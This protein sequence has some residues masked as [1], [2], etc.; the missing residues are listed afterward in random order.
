VLGIV[1]GHGGFV[2]VASKVGQ[3]TTFELY[4]PATKAEQVALKKESAT[5]WPRAHSEGIL[6]VD[7]EAAV[8]E[9]T[10]QALVEFGYRVITAGR[11][12]EAI[13]IFQERR[14]EI[15]LVLTD[16][17]MPEMDGPTLVAALRVLDPSV[18]IVGV[19]GTSD[20]AGMS[21]LKTLAL[22]AMLA[23]PFTINKLLAVIKEALPVTAGPERA[24]PDGGESRLAP[25]G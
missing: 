22:S 1:R 8:C 11:G 7:D 17:M 12:T 6:L 4:F 9:V 16:M 5:P 15:Q 2:R 3:G 10:R 19:T 13:N 20:T 18:R 23:K 25:P 24:V 14:D 21:D